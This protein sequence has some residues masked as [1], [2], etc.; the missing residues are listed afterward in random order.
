MAS[1]VIA[2]IGEGSRARR[3]LTGGEA[4]AH[5]LRQTAPDV[6]PVSPI[7]PQTPIIETFAR[8]VADGSVASELLNVESEH[9]AMSAAVGAS[10]A[11]ARVATATASQ[12]LALMLEVLHI[13]SAMRAPM[14]VAVGDRA[15][16]GPTNIHCD[17][18]DIMLARD[19][20]AVQLFA[21]DAQEAYDFVLLATRIAEHP[22]VRLPVL[23]GL[24]GFSVT[25]L[26]E[27]VALLDDATARDF[28]GSSKPTHSLLDTVHPTT[29]GTLAMPD[30]FFEFRR[31]QVAA[32][33][34]VLEE[35]GGIV[36]DLARV[37]GR[38]YDV[39]DAYRLT[40]AVRALV[41]LGSTAGTVKDVVD[42]LR[43]DGERVGLL[44]LHAFRPLPRA[45]VRRTLAG[46]AHVA[47]L[48][49]ALSPGGP[50]PLYAEIAAVVPSGGSRILSHVYGLGGRELEPRQVRELFAGL[51]HRDDSS[52][53]CYVG[54]RE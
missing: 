13:A 32:L 10:L 16:S 41:L 45:A 36:G 33:D 8:F 22:R 5:A 40:D 1:A 15:L 52:D 31:Q 21:Q 19:S 48:D 6:V 49:R 35:W 7:T 20:G 54:L 43:K 26:A 42:E 34:A 53:T 24:D 38:T 47:V 3:L 30:V 37:T 12:G 2:P 17:H 18:S 46:V 51:V 29:Q 14:L 39:V 9:S 4:V 23:V 28:V 27:P 44:T 11:G 25:H 50:P